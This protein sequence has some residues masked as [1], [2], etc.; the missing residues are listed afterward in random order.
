M[1]F[2]ELATNAMKYG[3]LGGEHGSV[4][5][6]WSIEELPQGKRL[7]LSW[8]EQNGPMVLPPHREGF[9]SRLIRRSLGAH[10]GSDVTLTYPPEG[11]VCTALIAL[12]E[13]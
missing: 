8:T 7:H 9:G 4:D 10:A 1:A 13:L 6:R 5:I 11:F 2:H 3:A 12:P